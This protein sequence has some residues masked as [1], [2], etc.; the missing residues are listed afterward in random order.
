[1]AALPTKQ[2]SPAPQPGTG[3]VWEDMMLWG[4]LCLPMAD[5]D[6]CCVQPWVIP[7]GNGQIL[8]FLCPHFSHACARHEVLEI[9]SNK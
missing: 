4:R 2:S 1:M 9:T 8:H 7:N 6:G 3:Q 5:V